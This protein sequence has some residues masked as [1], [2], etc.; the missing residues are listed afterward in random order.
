MRLLI[1]LARLF[2]YY[3]EKQ[4]RVLCQRDGK[5]WEF[6]DG[7]FYTERSAQAV[8][9]QRQVDYSNRQDWKFKIA[10]EHVFSRD[11]SA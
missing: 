11:V 9:A 8:L 2:G 5:T 1:W 7:P 10:V 6:W 4:W 3:L